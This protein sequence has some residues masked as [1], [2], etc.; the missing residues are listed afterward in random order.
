[1]I[2]KNKNEYGIYEDEKNKADAHNAIKLENEKKAQDVRNA[3]EKS[4]LEKSEQEL[5]KINSKKDSVGKTVELVLHKE[6]GFLSKKERDFLHSISKKRVLS[7]K[8]DSWLRSIAA[9]FNV[10]SKANIKANNS[11]GSYDDEPD[12]PVQREDGSWY[13]AETGLEI[14]NPKYQKSYF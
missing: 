12:M 7:E 2:A 11:H 6:N 8:Q 5:K 14:T 9:R 3:E 1:M 10:E 4:R 13:D